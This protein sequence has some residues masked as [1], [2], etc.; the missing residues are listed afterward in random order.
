MAVQQCRVVTECDYHNESKNSALYCIL[1]WP[2]F[3]S[4]WVALGYS[5]PGYSGSSAARPGNA[6]ANACWSNDKCFIRF[7]SNPSSS[8]GHI[9]LAIISRSLAAER[10]I[11]R[12]A[13]LRNWG[14]LMRPGL[15]RT[16]LAAPAGRQHW[17]GAGLV[18]RPVFHH[19]GQDK[20]RSQR[21]AALLQRL[22]MIERPVVTARASA[23]PHIG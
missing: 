20:V 7:L 21:G 8:T 23:I 14:P 15:M 1:R 3:S 11:T 9:Y 5:V 4:R 10:L 17:S 18:L 22:R 2:V 12:T 19:L 13:R 16:R 6:A